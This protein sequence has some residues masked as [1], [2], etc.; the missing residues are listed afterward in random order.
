VEEAALLAAL[1]GAD[2]NGDGVI[3]W[4]EFLAAMSPDML[5]QEDNLARVFQVGGGQGA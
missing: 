5:L 1:Q 2:L 4:E 3:D